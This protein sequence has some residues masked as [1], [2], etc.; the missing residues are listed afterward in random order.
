MMRWRWP[1][2]SSTHA[3]PQ[4]PTGTTY[5]VQAGDTV[6]GLALRFG[7]S[8]W[9]IVAANNLTNPNLIYIGQVLI[10]P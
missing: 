3:Q 10:I 8:T 5:V 9:S 7:V 2:V 1:T 4:P 6:S